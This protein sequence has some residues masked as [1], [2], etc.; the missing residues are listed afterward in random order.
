VVQKPNESP[1]FRVNF[2][3][4]EKGNNGRLKRR[5]YEFVVLCCSF[6]G[7]WCNGQG[8]WVGSTLYGRDS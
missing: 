3:V 2:S 1:T 5:P 8:S 6:V 7:K 4:G